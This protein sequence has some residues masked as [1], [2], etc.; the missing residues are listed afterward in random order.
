MVSASKI[1]MPVE[2]RCE[3][4]INITDDVVYSKES[5]MQKVNMELKAKHYSLKTNKNRQVI[6]GKS[7]N[8]MKPIAYRTDEK[9]KRGG[10]HQDLR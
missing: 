3:I 4:D 6:R 8:E 5:H 1:P 2:D 9:P 10:Y 7:D